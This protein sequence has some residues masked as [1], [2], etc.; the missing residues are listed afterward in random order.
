MYFWPEDDPGHWTVRGVAGETAQWLGRLRPFILGGILLSIWPAMDPALVEPPAFL[1]TDPE[2]VDERFTRC[3]RGRGHACV[4]DGDT[5]KLGERKIRIIGIDAPELRG[6]CPAET[7]LAE[8]A[9]ARLQ[10]LLNQGPFVMV[11]RIDDMRDRYGRDLRALSRTQADGTEQSIA[12]D[13]RASG[14]ARRY[15]GFKEGWC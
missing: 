8:A 4:I 11:G 12:A 15:K 13:M 14:L 9:T 5:F 7:R 2:Q 3:G 1:S 10:A 6:Q